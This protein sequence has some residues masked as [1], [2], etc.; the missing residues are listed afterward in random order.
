MLFNQ[1]TPYI[2]NIQTPIINLQTQRDKYSINKSQPPGAT[3]LKHSYF[4]SIAIDFD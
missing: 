4:C 2:K 3:L 1:V